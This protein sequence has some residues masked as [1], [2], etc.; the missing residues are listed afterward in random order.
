MSF[1]QMQ[2]TIAQPVSVSG[3]GYWSGQQVQVEFRPAS[4]GTGIR[5]YREDLPGQPEVPAQWAYRLATPR[6]SS[7]RAEQAEVQMVEHILA[8]LYGLEIDNCQVWVSGA[9]MP[10]LDGSALPFVE[11]LEQAGIV[12]QPVYRCV[13]VI[14][15]RLRLTD[16]D[17]WIEVRPSPLGQTVLEYHLDYGPT[18]PIGRQ[19][20]RTV[21]TPENFRRE[22]APARTFL[23][24]QEAEA[25]LAQGLGLRTRPE[26]LLV[27]DRHGLIN[28]HLRFADEC[29]RHKLLD[30]IGDL[31]LAGCR[32]IGEFV[33]FRSG[34]R[35]NGELVQ[36][37]ENLANSESQCMKQCA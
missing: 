35:L 29:A 20:F 24:R 14:T 10:G 2:R 11:A 19:T 8:A 6:R 26:D 17:S 18:S 1:N 33:A 21:L 32:F 7:L 25:L 23:L 3:Y 12:L 31:A 28:N 4:A 9:E 16:A 22:I 5:F 36:I 34:H 15:Q 13:K 37:L 30:L 27:F